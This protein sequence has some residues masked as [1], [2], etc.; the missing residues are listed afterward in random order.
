[1]ATIKEKGVWHGTEE[2][3]LYNMDLFALC[4]FNPFIFR[5][6]T[7]R[8]MEISESPNHERKSS[9]QWGSLYFS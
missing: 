2:K 5:I 8:A 9:I 1:M 6:I 3:S 7:V 4:S